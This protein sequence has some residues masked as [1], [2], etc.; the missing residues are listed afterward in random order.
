MA[1]R[2]NEKDAR[3]CALSTSHAVEAFNEDSREVVCHR[4]SCHDLAQVSVL[5]DR[6][7]AAKL[8]AEAFGDKRVAIHAG[9]GIFTT[10]ATVDEAVRADEQLL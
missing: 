9:H 8:F 2:T 7:A 4:G 6:N 10:G 1:H 5:G 3:R